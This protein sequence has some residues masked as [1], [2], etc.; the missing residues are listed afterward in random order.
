[1]KNNL[2]GV[3]DQTYPGANTYFDSPARED[4]SQ[5]WVDF[6]NHLLACGIVFANCLFNAF[7]NHYQSGANVES[8]TSA[9]QKLLKSMKHLRR[10]FL[11]FQKT[12]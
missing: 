6:A 12:I 5:K 9:S 8:T 3:L 2:I 7:I 11:Y 10:S 1:M 4:G